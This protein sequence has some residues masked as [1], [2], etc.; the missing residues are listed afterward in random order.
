MEF[1]KLPWVFN[2]K[3]GSTLVLR[4][5]S[6]RPHM[7]SGKLPHSA[8]LEVGIGSQLLQLRWGGG[9]TS[10]PVLIRIIP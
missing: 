1:G 5:A 2:S 7:G 3:G 9:D 10:L 6:V 8:C 4:C